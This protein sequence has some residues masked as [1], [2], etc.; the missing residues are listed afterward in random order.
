MNERSTTSI[1]PL[2]RTTEDL[3]SLL[4]C[5]SCKVFRSQLNLSTP[6][7]SVLSI[8][9]HSFYEHTG[10]LCHTVSTEISARHV[11][12]T[13][14]MEHRSNVYRCCLHWDFCFAFALV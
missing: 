1:T 3:S 7:F 6:L 2:R 10:N 14:F 9:F 11:F 13:K 12:F 8:S 5:L 4:T